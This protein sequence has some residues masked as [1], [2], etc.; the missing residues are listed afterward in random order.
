MTSLAYLAFPCLACSWHDKT[1]VAVLLC[2]LLCTGTEREPSI[3]SEDG[4]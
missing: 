3:G 1:G 2:R 4:V